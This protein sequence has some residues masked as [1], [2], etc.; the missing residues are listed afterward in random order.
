MQRGFKSKAERISLAERQ[1]IGLTHLCRL[2]PRQLAGS[3]GIRVMSVSDLSGL[4][5]GHLTQLIEV[6]PSAFSGVTIACGTSRLIVVNDS[7]T[8]QRRANTIAHEIAHCLLDHAPSSLFGRWGRE[9]DKDTEDEADWLAGCLL[10][11]GTGVQETMQRCGQDLDA[12]A[13]HYGVSIELMRWRHNSQRWRSK[14]A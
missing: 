14:A 10:V 13:S 9:L 12:A 7:H 3:H 1:R 11:P 2:D 8:D 6:D 5:S 4:S